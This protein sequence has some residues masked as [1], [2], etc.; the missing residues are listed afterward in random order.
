MLLRYLK[1]Q[2]LI[3]LGLF[4]ILTGCS[5]QSNKISNE[6]S[7]TKNIVSRVVYEDKENIKSEMTISS[8]CILPLS[9]SE[10]S[11][12]KEYSKSKSDH[13]LTGLSPTEICKLYFHAVKTRDISTQYA[14]YIQGDEYLVPSYK[15]FLKETSNTV[16]IENTKLLIDKLEQ[17]VEVVRER[18]IDSKHAVVEIISKSGNNDIQFSV[19]K[20]NGGIWKAAW[21]PLQ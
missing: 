6:E 5:H 1:P 9:D 18:T 8:T 7:H 15:Q 3:F 17:D 14:C 2:L 16:D 11:T 21:M 19:I 4:F 13:I 10:M 12:Y 20:T